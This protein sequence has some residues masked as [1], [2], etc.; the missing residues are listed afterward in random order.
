MGSD[1]DLPVMQ[2]ASTLLTEFGIDHKVHTLSADHSRDALIS[3]VK[4]AEADGYKALICAAGDAAQLSAAVAAHT[5]LPVIS[6]PILRT[7][8][9]SVDALY[10]ALQ[11]PTDT[12]IVTV[13]VNGAKNAAILAAQII[14]TGDTAMRT[15][16]TAYKEKMATEVHAKN[17][18]LQALGVTAYL[19]STQM[20]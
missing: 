12:P 17:Q 15:K 4:N 20:V 1:S 8:T 7:S 11:M 16:V 19:N 13:A 2:E 6:V 9:E 3:Y 14:G 5:T 10:S 18:E